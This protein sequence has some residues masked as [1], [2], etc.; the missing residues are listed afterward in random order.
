MFDLSCNRLAVL[1]ALLL[2]MFSTGCSSTIS[3]PVRHLSS[4]VC[5]V[6]PESTTR[7]EVLSFLGEPDRKITT[8]EKSEVWL[9]L[10]VNKSFSKKLPLLGA[11]LGSQ[12]YET[13]TVTFDGD[14]VKTCLYRQFDEDEF[15]KFSAELP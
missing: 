6:M 1:F 11:K 14:L 12:N 9:Y 13:V 8:A 10:K 3:P 2:F 4:D 5:L 15:E 7:Q